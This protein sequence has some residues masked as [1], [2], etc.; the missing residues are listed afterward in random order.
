MIVTCVDS[1]PGGHSFADLQR[2]GLLGSRICR[3][4]RGCCGSDDCRQT[5]TRGQSRL[6]QSSRGPCSWAENLSVAG[7]TGNR[8]SAHRGSVQDLAPTSVA[9][10]RKMRLDER[11]FQ[12][13]HITGI[14]STALIVAPVLCSP[15]VRSRKSSRGSYRITTIHWTQLSSG[16]ALI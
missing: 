9:L 11:P 2:R 15:H 14:S 7:A 4:I 12:V 5:G 16:Q 13:R 8:S 10:R 3:T 1:H 6:P